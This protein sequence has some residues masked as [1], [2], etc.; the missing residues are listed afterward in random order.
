MDLGIVGRT[1]LVTGASKG[2]GF[3]IARRLAEEGAA[4]A[5]S[6]RSGP[7]I[8]RAAAAIGAT[9]FVF[10]SSDVERADGLVSEVEDRLG[11]VDILIANTGGPPRGADPLGFDS[12]AWEKAHRDL[13][14][15]PMAL[16]ERVLPG[17]RERGF[18]RIVAIGSVA[19]REPIGDL[20]LSNA[21]RSALLAAFK[22]LARAVA[23]AGVTANTVHPGLIA[24]DRL[25]ERYGS[26]EAA[27]EAAAPAIPARRLGTVDEL[28]DVAAFLCSAN[29]A[30][31][32]GTDVTVDG[33]L[34]RS[35]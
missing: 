32:T 19:V 27:T 6:S 9:P 18:G 20:M 4:V 5:I 34:T 28:A 3:G 22:T 33:G 24:T 14:R 1:A 2:I 12:D 31:V 15:S 26:L 10:D 7:R 17:M 21:Y 16:V 29:A 23:A 25:I 13:L 30:Y 35:V 8:E 11:P